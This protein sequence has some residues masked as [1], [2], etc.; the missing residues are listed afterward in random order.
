M[1]K[2]AIEDFKRNKVRTLLTSLGIMI[3]VL[4]VVLLIALGLGLKNYIK[5]Q[6]ESLGANLIIIFPG[7]IS[8]DEGGGVSN[9]GAGFAGGASFDEKDLNSLSRINE[10]DYLVPLFMKSSFIETGT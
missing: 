1:V 9:F 8:G 4:S 2:T 6:F 3:G 7:N 5:Q 10:A